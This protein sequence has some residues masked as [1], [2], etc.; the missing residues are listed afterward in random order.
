MLKPF[1]KRALARENLSTEEV[2]QAFG[3]IM[4][5]EASPAQ[6]AA[7]L[8]ALRCKGETVDE[9]TGAATAMRNRMNP[10]TVTRRPLIDTCGTGGS[11]KGKF[12]I[13]T[14]VAFIVS[15]AGVAV[16]KHGN[17]AISS[18]SGSA[19]VLAELGVNITADQSTVEQCVNEL[20]IGFLFAPNCHP[21]MKYAAPVRREMG[22]RTLFNVLGPLTNPASAPR[23]LMGVFA[24][25]L[26]EPLATVLG[27]L[28]SEYAWVIHGEDG[29]DE[30]TVCG[31]TQVSEWDGAQVNSITIDPTTLGISI[32]PE[33]SLRGGTPAENAAVFRE[34]LQG[35]LSGAICDAVALNTGAALLIAGIADS[36]E[37]GYQK[38]MEIIRSGEAYG[39]LES[40][41]RMSQSS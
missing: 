5:G 27:R 16:A 22:V 3:H 12:N 15:T 41:V 7:L 36:L 19:D 21:A 17:R 38:S 35:K 37:A 39:T 28:K 9:L 29:L 40:L 23:Q 20:G 18:K 2:V 1:I 10:I 8:I 6:I 25:E 34:L 30:I 13:S 32:Y 14:A 24:P 11:G 33:D 4:D 31:K 26:T